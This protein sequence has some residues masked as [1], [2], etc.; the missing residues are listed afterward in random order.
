[1]STS[2]STIDSYHLNM[3]LEAGRRGDLIVVEGGRNTG[4]TMLTN[5]CLAANKI[6]QDKVW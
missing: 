4:K 1:M 3:M 2:S 5:A 6:D